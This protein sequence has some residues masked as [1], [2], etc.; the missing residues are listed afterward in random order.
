MDVVAINYEA[1][2][3]LALEHATSEI[4]LDFTNYVRDVMVASTNVLELVTLRPPP[5]VGMER[6]LLEVEV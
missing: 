1:I 2:S 5:S 3:Y 4:A 6:V